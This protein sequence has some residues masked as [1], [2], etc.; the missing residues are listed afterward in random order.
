MKRASERIHGTTSRGD[1]VG[2]APHRRVRT[3]SKPGS[4][5]NRNSRY[6]RDDRDYRN[7]KNNRR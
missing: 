5:A 7:P 1:Q 6:G 4:T 2:Q 3:T